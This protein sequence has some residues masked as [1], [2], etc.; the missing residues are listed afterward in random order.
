MMNCGTSN[1]EHRTLNVEGVFFCGIMTLVK[2]FNALP[3]NQL[4]RKHMNCA[5]EIL[6]ASVC[7]FRHSPLAGA[8][9]E[10][11][12]S[13]WNVTQGCGCCAALPW[14]TMCRPYGAWMTKV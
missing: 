12:R 13:I 11:R 9:D 14:A 2:T 7:F 1:I 10:K 3:S 4:C 5:L 8:N 6:L